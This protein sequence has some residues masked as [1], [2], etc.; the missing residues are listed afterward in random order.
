MVNNNFEDVALIDIKPLLEKKL[1]K[2]LNRKKLSHLARMKQ[3][4]G[5]Y[6]IGHQW[7]IS[8][9]NAQIFI[10]SYLPHRHGERGEDK[11]KRKKRGP[12]VSRGLI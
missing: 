9:V 8:K 2:N 11:T 1:K 6:K 10:D 4:N 12:N 3:I 5:V 7:Y